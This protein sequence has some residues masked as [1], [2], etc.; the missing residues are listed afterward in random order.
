MRM[1]Y[2]LLV[3]DAPCS[4]TLGRRTSHFEFNADFH[5]LR[6]GNL[7]I[8]ARSLRVVMHE[9][10]Q[11]LAPARHAGPVPGSDD[12]LVSG[13]VRHLARVAL[14]DLAAR[15]CELKPL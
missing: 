6:A 14:G 15:H 1:P 7:E 10:E 4:Q 12:R 13:V 8:G 3:P 2:G 11:L 9:G 5:H